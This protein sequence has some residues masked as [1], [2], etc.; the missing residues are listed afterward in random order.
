MS[1]SVFSILHV[2][3]SLVGI[4]SGFTVIYGLLASEPA[5]FST[6]LFLTSTSATSMSGFLFPFHGLLA[7]SGHRHH[8]IDIAHTQQR[9]EHRHGRDRRNAADAVTGGAAEGPPRHLYT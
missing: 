1:L 9:H 8:G 7:G 4:G 2:V 6:K 3:L 5:V